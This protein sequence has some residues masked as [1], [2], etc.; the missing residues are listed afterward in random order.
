MLFHSPSPVHYTSLSRQDTPQS[1]NIEKNK[2]R[3]SII[4]IKFLYAQRVGT[5]QYKL[6]LLNWD[7]MSEHKTYAET[8]KFFSHE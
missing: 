3:K 5:H 1:T 2:Q 6:I 4:E 7:N 8:F